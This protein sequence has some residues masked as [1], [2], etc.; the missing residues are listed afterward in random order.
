VVTIGERAL[1][2]EARLNAI[3]AEVAIGYPLALAADTRA[4]WA[5]DAQGRVWRID[6]GTATVTHTTPVGRGLVGLCATETAVWAANN[7]DGTVIRIDP[8]DGQVIDRVW[9]GR[10]PTDV[11]VQDGNVWVSIQ[12]ESAM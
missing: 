2:I 10:A 5:S 8:E 9:I 3:T 6:P 4:M 11:A 1:R 7:L 12:G